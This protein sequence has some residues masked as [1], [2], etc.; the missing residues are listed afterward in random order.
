MNGDYMMNG[1]RELFQKV[2]DGEDF[3]TD[4]INL[5]SEL[6][7]GPVCR[8]ASR[9][10]QEQYAE[11]LPDFLELKPLI[12][13]C[14]PRKET[15]LK[16]I[17]DQFQMDGVAEKAPMLCEVNEAFFDSW[18]SA[19]IGFYVYS[20]EVDPNARGPQAYIRSSKVINN[21]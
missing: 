9:L 14:K 11:I 5:I 6:I 19:G 13:F 16:G 1:M 15:I 8:G 2:R 17:R 3:I 7:Y 10:S 12:F 4:R 20:Y 21:E 18:W